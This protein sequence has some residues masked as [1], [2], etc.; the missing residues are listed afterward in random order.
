M[1]EEEVFVERKFPA[2][3]SRF[4]SGFRCA[5]GF[6]CTAGKFIS[7]AGVT[8]KSSNNSLNHKSFVKYRIPRVVT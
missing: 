5:D 8:G 2:N 7:A 4:G 1:P 3:D 6:F